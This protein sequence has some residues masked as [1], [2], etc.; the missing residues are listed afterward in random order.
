MAAMIAIVTAATML[1]TRQ[2]AIFFTTMNPTITAIM[3]KM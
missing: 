1:F 2:L 3:Q